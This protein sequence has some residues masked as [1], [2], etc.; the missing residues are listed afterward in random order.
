MEDRKLWNGGKKKVKA[1]LTLSG[2]HKSMHFS[3][4]AIRLIGVP[5][6][7]SFRVNKEFST[8]V[9]VPSNGNENLSFRVPENL[10]TD[11]NVNMAVS[12]KKFVGKLMEAND[13][14]ETTTYLIGGIYS[15]V[16]NALV[17]PM[18]EAEEYCG[19]KYI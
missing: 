17:F 3:K 2:K 4:D 8:L 7:I 5:S 16:N 11:N 14:R 13:F 10:C 15:E 9:V 18:S 12:S 6:H 19:K 1:Y